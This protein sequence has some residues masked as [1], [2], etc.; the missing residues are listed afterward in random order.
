MPFA[1]YEACVVSLSDTEIMLIGGAGNDQGVWNEVHKLT[2][3]TGWEA[4]APMGTARVG[5]C[6]VLE[7]QEEVIS[8][9]GYTSG[10][11]VTDTMEIY[12]VATNVWRYGA[13][14]PSLTAW[15]FCNHEN[16]VWIVGKEEDQVF[17]YDGSGQQWIH[18]T[19]IKSPGLA[20]GAII[21][22]DVDDTL[23]CS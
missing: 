15:S 7:G 19:D 22:V 20:V 9:G 12:N 6:A 11:A 18:Q 16:T 10:W 3:G 17:K 21:L 1:V 4:L 23:K 13:S 8:A 5:G 14:L 2:I